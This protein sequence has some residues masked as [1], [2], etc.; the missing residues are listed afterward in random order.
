[1]SGD[2]RVLR[3]TPD[4]TMMDTEVK[5]RPPG[6]PPDGA[7]S[8]AQKVTGSNAGGML[9]PEM[10]LD[11]A[12]VEERVNLAFP[13][14]ED[15][16][17][18]I[19]IEREVL[20]AMNGLW[21]NCMIVK[22]LGRNVPISTLSRRLRE[23]WKPSGAMYVMDLPRQFFMVRFAVE[24]EYLMALTGGPWKAFGSYLMVQAWSPHFDPVTDDIV[25]TPVW[26]RL[27]N[28]PVTFY[29]KSILMGIARGLGKPI[30]VDPTTLRFERARFAR[31][32][33]EVDLRKPL[34]G[35]VQINGDRYFVS[36]EGLAAICSG[37]GL[38]GHLVHSCPRNVSERVNSPE[39]TVVPAIQSDTTRG[40]DM[41]PVDEGFTEVRRGSRRM[42]QPQRLMEAAGASGGG[43]LGRNLRE[44]TSKDTGNISLSNKFGELEV[45]EIIPEKEAENPQTEANKE[46]IRVW[47]QARKGNGGNLGKEV[48]VGAVLDKIK[49]ATRDGP[50]ERR[51]HLNKGVENNGPKLKNKPNR[52]TRGLVFGS[53]REEAHVFSNGK[54]L[55]IEKDSVGRP[56]GAFSNENAGMKDPEPLALMEATEADVNVEEESRRQEVTMQDGSSAGPAN[57]IVA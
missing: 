35:S 24:D 2:F 32:C 54:R 38:Y 10:V 31:V 16:E 47:F 44:I 12:F 17:P 51:A 50:R 37:C 43:D 45:E 56:G 30:R 18:V 8:W 20:E 33:V 52:S 34:K 29:Q 11:E 5:D 21:K 46:N 53:A 22:V 9:S 42:N 1:M 19:T 4:A 25:T 23:M 13:D 28:I 26:V 3:E 6:D 55:R 48:R 49:F 57:Q 15:G 36:Y 7:V 41:L 14:G 27:S 40:N 39:R